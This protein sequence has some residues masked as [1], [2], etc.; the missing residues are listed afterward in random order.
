MI[1]RGVFFAVV[2]SFALPAFSQI[3]NRVQDRV[4]SVESKKARLYA[5]ADQLRTDP[6]ARIAPA[7]AASVNQLAAIQ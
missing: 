4:L 2:L 5:F 6:R 3:F 7:R 1:T